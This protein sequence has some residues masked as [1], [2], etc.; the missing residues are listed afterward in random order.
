MNII[1]IKSFFILVIFFALPNF[2]S[3]ATWYVRTDGGTLTECTGLADAAYPGSGTAQACAVNHPFWLLPPGDVAVIAGGDTVMI[4][5]GSYKMGAGAPNTGMSACNA[6]WTYQCVTPSIPSGPD[7][8]HPTRIIGQNWDTK[9]TSAPELW[10][11]GRAT[12]ILSL[13][14]SSNVELM[15]LDITDHLQ[16]GYNFTSNPTLLCNRS[17]APYGDQA[18]YGIYA[19]DSAN[20][21]L[22]DIKIHGLSN[23]AIW[24]G[25]LTDWTFD[26]VNI[27]GNAF[28]GWNGDVGHGAFGSG[29]DSSMHGTILFKNSKINYTGCVE[30]YPLTGVYPDIA[31]GGCYGQG[32]GGYGDGLGMYF[33][34]GDWIFEDSEFMHNTQD[35]IDLLYHIGTTGS[36]KANRI[37]AEG[38]VGQ[39]IKFG[40]NSFV[41][42]S[43]IIGDCN[44]FFNN[45][46]AFQAGFPNCRAAGTPIM[47][48]NWRSGRESSIVNSTIIGPNKVFVEIGTGGGAT[49]AGLSG[50]LT[51]VP[52]ITA[53]GQYVIDQ[54]SDT[55][56]VKLASSVDANTTQILPRVGTTSYVLPNSWIADGN[57]IYHMTGIG[58]ITGGNYIF[59]AVY[60]TSVDGSAATIVSD[61]Q[62]AVNLSVDSIWLRLPGNQDPNTFDIVLQYNNY[63]TKKTLTGTWIADDNG[64][65]HMTGIGSQT[66]GFYAF[67]SLTRSGVCDGTQKV[68]SRNNIF[69][70]MEWW[71]ASQVGI[72][73]GTYADTFYLDGW[74]G[75]GDGS[76]AATNP[77]LFD[78]K[79]S[80]VFNSKFNLCSVPNNVL[81]VNPLLQNV[82]P[83]TAYNDI[84]TYGE[85]WDVV[86]QIGS[87]AIDMASSIAGSTVFGAVTIPAVDILGNSRP[88]GAGIDWGAYEVG[89]AVDIVAP[90][91]PS[92][93]SVF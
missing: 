80:I 37:R 33:T 14:G 87:P 22:K 89:S 6:A 15:Y 43:V 39:Q 71:S 45:P 9:S 51:N 25:R 90:G 41:E 65:Y 74:S 26:G 73:P 29:T 36:I 58:V 48:S 53:I 19:K 21:L 20:V 40:G 67:N 76:C 34:A 38:N 54:A 57:G 78:N 13:V 88:F 50:S 27:H 7:A 93:L 30:N 63:N 1:N 35:G 3:A 18:D 12:Q 92:G 82:P 64:I 32:Q 17:V 49:Q 75:N 62:Y 28:S 31:T 91:A 84:Y 56:W 52:S 70:G 44:Y 60:Y 69:A 42:N 77:V 59:N 2:A 5:N 46:I 72:V 24:A 83:Y 68:Y 61:N 55:M 4:G 10:G 47:L 8:L 81:C 11:S 86:P 66:D 23:G 85:R 16:C 79:D